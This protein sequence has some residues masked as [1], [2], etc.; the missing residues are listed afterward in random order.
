MD[1]FNATAACETFIQ[2]RELQNDSSGRFF[3]EN[4]IARRLLACRD[5]LT[6]AYTEVYF[7]LRS[8]GHLRTFWGLVL[9][10]AAEWGS[11]AGTLMPW[12]S[13]LS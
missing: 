12:P 4:V 10:A 5:Q 13:E 7:S 8:D 2:E 9:S 11:R 3:S 6:D 1:P